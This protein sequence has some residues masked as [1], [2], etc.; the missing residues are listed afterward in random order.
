M[1]KTKNG[2]QKK[3]QQQ[4]MI[5]YRKC[6]KTSRTRMPA[7]HTQQAAKI[8]VCRHCCFVSLLVYLFWDI[9]QNCS[10]V[11]VAG[12]LLVLVQYAKYFTTSWFLSFPP[13]SLIYLAYLQKIA[14]LLRK[15]HVKNHIMFS[16]GTLN[17]YQSADF[18]AFLLFTFIF[19][20]YLNKIHLLWLSDIRRYYRFRNTT[21][22]LRI[23][24]FL[25]SWFLSFSYLHVQGI[26]R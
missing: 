1:R 21:F 6:N 14:Q 2:R 15:L 11:R 7:R 10:S 5:D 20:V 8:N 9:F 24:F 16:L 18:I 12:L 26:W 4:L 25:I 23:Q 22:K 19:S 13:F 17:R 3:K